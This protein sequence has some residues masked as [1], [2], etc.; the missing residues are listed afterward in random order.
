MK[1]C[2]CDEITFEVFYL[3]TIQLYM[4][5]LQ[6][7]NAIQEKISQYVLSQCQCHGV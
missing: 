3:F 5:L 1:H 4:I 7:K 2:D 6:F